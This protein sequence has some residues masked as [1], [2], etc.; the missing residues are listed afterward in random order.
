MKENIEKIF[1]DIQNDIFYKAEQFLKEKTKKVLDY[2][3]FTKLWIILM[4]LHLSGW[5]GDEKCELKIK[6]E[7]GSDIRVIPFKQKELNEKI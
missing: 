6:E 7:T 5:C 1:E 3:E 4:D 2:R